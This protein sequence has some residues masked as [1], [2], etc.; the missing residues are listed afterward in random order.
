MANG[1]PLLPHFFEK[2]IQNWADRRQPAPE[3]QVEV[4]RHR[5]YILP[6]QHGLVF[7]AMLLLVLSGAVNYENSLAFMLT[8]LLGSLGLLGMVYT[9]Q[10]INRLKVRIGQAESVFAGQRILF[11]ITVIQPGEHLRPSIKLESET[12]QS[13]SLH[14]MNEKSISCKLPMIAHHRGYISP[15]RIKLFTEYPLGLFHAWSWLNLKARCL[16]YPAPDPHPCTLHSSAGQVPGKNSSQ[17]YGVDEFAGIRTYQPGDMANHMAWKAIAKTGELQT[18]LF[19]NDSSEEI[20]ISWSQT[21]ETYDIEK[22]LSILCRMIIDADAQSIKYALHVPGTDIAGA[23]G[24]QHK[25]RCLKV[26]ALYGQNE[27]T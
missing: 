11:P 27:H 21:S 12:G 23:S 3:H 15:R 22:R 17:Q 14:L 20:T 6:T 25:H 16:V 24:L 7:F 5:L 26:L 18:K 13:V 10:N 1:L 2:F 9:H 19:N 8:F 4:N